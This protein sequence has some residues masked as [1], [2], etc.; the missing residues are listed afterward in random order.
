M[1]A[2]IKVRHWLNLLS[3]CGSFL[4]SL[5]LGCLGA[6]HCTS[7]PSCI[8]PHRVDLNQSRG[9]GYLLY[10]DSNPDLISDC[11]TD[12]ATCLLHTSLMSDGHL[13]PSQSHTK[14]FILS[15]LSHLHKLLRTSSQTKKK[16]GGDICSLSVAHIS[17]VN[18][19]GSAS[20]PYFEHDLFQCLPLSLPRH[21]PHRFSPGL[22]PLTPDG[23]SCIYP[24]LLQPI[25][26]RVTRQNF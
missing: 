10:A 4:I 18:P 1:A 5:I 20:K 3:I 24:C 2:I 15:S 25:L 12:V 23:S 9:F 8:Y 13:K 21:K 16:G 11:Q 26:S 22:P 14:L 6:H 17:K 7:L 19:D